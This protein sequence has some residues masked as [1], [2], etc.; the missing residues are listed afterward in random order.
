MFKSMLDKVIDGLLDKVI[1]RSAF[2]YLDMHKSK[3][4]AVGLKL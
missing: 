2:V 1:I 4:V 3:T